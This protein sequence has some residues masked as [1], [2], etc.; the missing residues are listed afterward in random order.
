VAGWLADWLVAVDGCSGKKMRRCCEKLRAKNADAKKGEQLRSFLNSRF[1][2]RTAELISAKYAQRWYHR[3][4]GK[5]ILMR[6]K[7]N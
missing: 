3:Q 4:K 1:Q 7:N 6:R 2:T 5:K